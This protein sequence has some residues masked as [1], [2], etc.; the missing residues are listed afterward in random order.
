VTAPPDDRACVTLRGQLHML[1]HY[2]VGW[3][4][5]L[6]DTETARQGCLPVCANYPYSN[7]AEHL[8]LYGPIMDGAIRGT[9]DTEIYKRDRRTAGTEVPRFNYTTAQLLDMRRAFIRELRRVRSERNLP[10]PLR[11]AH[12][13]FERFY[14]RR[15][16]PSLSKIARIR[17]REL[18]GR[19][20]PSGP[21]PI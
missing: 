13:A 16:L 12:W 8:I 21:A 5:G 10:L 1:L 4:Y 17:V 15:R 18:L 14:L 20:E 3:F 9:A 6:W 7:A 19:W 2:P 11:V